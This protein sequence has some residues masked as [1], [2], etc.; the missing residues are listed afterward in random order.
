MFDRNDLQRTFEPFVAKVI[1]YLCRTLG[2]RGLMMLARFDTEMPF[3]SVPALLPNSHDRNRYL[4][5]RS[6]STTSGRP[7]PPCDFS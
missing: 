5:P 6:K 4:P 2:N 3:L 7:P 1:W